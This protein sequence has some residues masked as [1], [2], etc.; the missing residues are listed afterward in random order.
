MKSSKE[1]LSERIERLTTAVSLGKP[2]RVPVVL[3][4]DSF[5]AHH[6]GITVAD[7]LSDLDKASETMLKSALALGEIDGTLGTIPIAHVTGASHLSTMSL[8]GRELK[9]NEI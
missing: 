3:G 9:E 6:L 2:D 4:A 1:L 7:L 8:P 5:A